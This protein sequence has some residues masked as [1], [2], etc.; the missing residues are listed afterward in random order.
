MRRH[1]PGSFG[2]AVGFVSGAVILPVM[3]G[4]DLKI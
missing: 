1:E 4:G 2:D 3:I